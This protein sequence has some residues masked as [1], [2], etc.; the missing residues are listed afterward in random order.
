MASRDS[1]E[2]RCCAGRLGARLGLAWRSAR[3]RR[4]DPEVRFEVCF[5]VFRG[6]PARVEELRLR[7]QR[8][9]DAQRFS[10][11][12]VLVLAPVLVLILREQVPSLA[13]ERG[14]GVGRHGVIVASGME[15]HR[16]MAVPGQGYLVGIRWRILAGVGEAMHM[17]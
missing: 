17:R 2:T 16:R 3:E 13:E 1:R 15:R 4:G 7:S 8:V 14:G 12:E 11:T 6:R 5:T 10:E 9:Y